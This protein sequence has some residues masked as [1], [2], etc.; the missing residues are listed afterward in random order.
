[1][2]RSAVGIVVFSLVTV[3]LSTENALALTQFRKAFTA[4]YVDDHKSDEFKVA[5][6]KATCNVC[7]VKSAK[8]TFHNEF[9]ESL[10]KLIEGDVTDRRKK[11]KAE[12]GLTA[13]KAELVKIL[14]ELEVAFTKVEEIKSHTGQTFGERMKEGQLPVDLEWAREQYKKKKAEEDKKAA[15]ALAE[16]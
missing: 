8:K 12:G 4:K 14:A 7:H 1:M 16:K 13:Y 11:A 6:K 3:T 15:E 9:G 2:M 5:V 10:K